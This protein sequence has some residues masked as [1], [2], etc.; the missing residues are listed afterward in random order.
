MPNDVSLC[1]I[2]SQSVQRYGINPIIQFT[3]VATNPSEVEQI[4]WIADRCPVG[5]FELTVNNLIQKLVLTV[6]PVSQ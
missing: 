4:K 1:M 5:S 2:I 3:Y 6:Q